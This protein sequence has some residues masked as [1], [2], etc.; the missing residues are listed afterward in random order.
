MPSVKYADLEFAM[1][2]VSGGELL[3]ARAYVSRGS[4]KIYWVS[5]E[6]AFEEDLPDDIDDPNQYAMVPDQRD[7]DL[8]KPLVLRF[9]AQ[10]MPD[11][12]AKINAMFRREGAYG[13]YKNFLSRHNLLE[14]WYK[15]EA[16]A[17][18]ELLCEWA[19]EEGFDVEAEPDKQ[20]T[21]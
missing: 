12:Y 8:G 5:D 6:D 19:V 4:G 21:Q 20:A 16:A 14:E 2:F 7:L 17:T 3:D 10:A 13:R 9:T 11:E 15:F 18:R 1:S